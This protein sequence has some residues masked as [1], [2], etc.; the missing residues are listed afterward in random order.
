VGHLFY[1]IYLFFRK[2]RLLFVTFL[3]AVL[4]F[5]G[6]FASKIHLEEDITKMIPVDGKIGML[7]HVFRSNKFVEKLVV[8]VSLADST[9]ESNPEKLIDYTNRFVAALEPLDSV[10]IKEITYRISEDAMLDVYNV[11]YEN[12]PVFLEESDY[13]EIENSIDSAVVSRKLKDNY[14]TLV[15][16]AGFAFKKFL[17]QDPLGLTNIGLK[18]LQNL[19]FDDNYEL[20][21]GYIITKNKRNL[22]LFIVPANP[23]HETSKN[24]EFI[25]ALDLTMDS[26]AT[27]NPEI[28][29]EY[30]GALAVAVGNANQIK[31][32]IHITVSI[33]LTILIIFI[34]LFYRRWNIFLL[35]FLPVIF[36][37]SIS[38]ALLYLI[39]DSVS[40]IAL[41]IG[42]V[43]L[44]ITLDFSLHIF[45]HFRRKGNV[46]TVL[47]DVATPIIISCFT[48]AAAFLCLLF[49]KSEAL[50]ELGLF[51][52]ISVVSA[53][54]MALLILPH[55]LKERGKGVIP[56]VSATHTSWLDKLAAIPLEKNKWLIIVVVLISIACAFTFK[57]VSFESDMNKMNYLSEEL[58]QAEDNLNK[59]HSY[60]LKSIFL[61]SS[62]KTIGDAL[63]KNEQTL[64]VIND[65]K[66]KGIVKKISAVSSLLI[67]DSL[68]NERIK[69]WQ[70]FWTEKRKSNLKNQLIQEGR[71]YKFK[72]SAF[73]EFFNLLNKD[74][75]PISISQFAELK[76]LFLKDYVTETD[77]MATITTL[78]KVEQQDMPKIYAAF[79]NNSETGKNKTDFFLLDKQ[80]LT[81][82]FIELLKDDFNLLV[83]LSFV[84]VLFILYVSLG[85]IELIL[86]TLAP[87]AGSWLWTLGIMGAFDIRFNIF[88][89]II[90]TFIFGLGIDY[91]IF[92]LKG[93]QQEYKWGVRNVDSYKTSILLSAITTICGVGVLI[94]AEHPALKSIALIS[95]IGILSVVLMAF[96]IQP[97]LFNFFILKRKKKGIVPITFFIFCY[98]TFVFIYFFIGC[99]ILTV[100]AFIL[101]MKM[102]KIKMFYHQ[103]MRFFTWSLTHM[104]PNVKKQ[105]INE[106]KED[107]K[108]PAV[109]IANHQSFLDI[110]I[111][112]SLHPKFILLTNKWV[113]NSPVFGR[114]VQKADYY[115]A[116]DS[117]GFE[118]NVE[119]LQAL[120][121]DGYSIVVFPEGTRSPTSKMGRMK[122]GAFFLAERFNL[123]VVPV[124]LHGMGD[125]MGKKDFLLSNGCMTIK[126]LKRIE[127]NDTSFGT[128]YSERTKK[129]SCHFKSE[130]QKVRDELESPAY[131][132][133]KLVKNY[134]FRGNMVEWYL[135]GKLRYENNW[136]LYDSII[137]KQGNIVDVGCGYGFLSYL[138]S[139]VSDQRNILGIDYDER[140]INIAQNVN[141]KTDAVNFECA[142]V[143]TYN[144]SPADAFIISDVLH[145]L[146]KEQQQTLLSK[147]F[148]NLNEGGVVLIRDADRNMPDR[149]FGTRFTEFISTTFG[150]NKT[151]GT[152]CFMSRDE[153][154]ACVQKHNL[155]I[156]IIDKTKFTSNVLFVVRK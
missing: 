73:G 106:E 34:S 102:K 10:Y 33:A 79:E 27:S 144:Y 78:L 20:H 69:R 49:V 24:S 23:T 124:I 148:Q 4:G 46:E 127:A 129:I 57:K 52:A 105:I 135:R 118:K 89:I 146:G 70:N 1:H 147:C 30:Y 93:L 50:Q 113:Y 71:K 58:Q 62:G 112:I 130:Y 2:Q 11:F 41:G 72:E 68:Q 15:S 145:Y 97:M 32:D 64:N 86:M 138:L 120:I 87:I 42:S 95:V 14:K 90:S 36:G 6:F 131:Y 123:D 125:I 83:L 59:I 116:T 21:D 31:S 111:M 54:V 82:K 19:Q 104:G 44:G 35:I 137:P 136:Q 122:K 88:N 48:T 7:N 12:L 92:V 154:I 143:T 108:K 3:L 109:V 139:F 56:H 149:H 28:N 8:S 96:T 110:I 37:G 63:R 74:F 101:P 115:H 142:D 134:L 67:S 80:Y 152:L 156:E 17:I 132:K 81:S 100:M 40:A 98:S 26:L 107:F 128:T 5:A 9:A 53:A 60:A 77:S 43:L 99:I 94:F 140:K 155:T 117:A 126:I 66:E 151:S 13:N 16:P 51:A 85:R 121:D 45:T 84:I 76:E 141:C 65:L 61:V 38:I 29:A 75:Q 91:S 103:T 47:K 114:V 119:H 133:D 39:K 153:I 25:A 55:L 18:K 22:L 150:F